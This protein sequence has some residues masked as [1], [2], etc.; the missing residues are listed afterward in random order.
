MQAQDLER[1]LDEFGLYVEINQLKLTT[2]V[3]S[4]RM[5]FIN[6]VMMSFLLLFTRGLSSTAV[7]T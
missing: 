7:L 5:V 3:A 4:I 1:R 2:G 6:G